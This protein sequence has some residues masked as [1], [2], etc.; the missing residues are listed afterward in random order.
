[1]DSLLDARRA[2]DGGDAVASRVGAA[3]E[4][5]CGLELQLKTKGVS[6]TQASATNGLF[7]L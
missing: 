6:A 1:M 5:A 2:C 4:L 3:G 7:I